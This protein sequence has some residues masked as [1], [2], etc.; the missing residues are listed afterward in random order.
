MMLYVRCSDVGR[1]ML[2]MGTILML[3]TCTL[4]TWTYLS[5]VSFSH[6]VQILFLTYKETRRQKTAFIWVSRNKMA[7]TLSNFCIFNVTCNSVMKRKCHCLLKKKNYLQLSGFILCYI[8]DKDVLP[9]IALSVRLYLN[10]E[11]ICRKECIGV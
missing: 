5:F 3:K 9:F 11:A 1:F 6:K 8:K 7:L 10:I 4:K 2:K